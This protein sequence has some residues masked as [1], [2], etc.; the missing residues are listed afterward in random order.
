MEEALPH[1][2]AEMPEMTH[3]APPVATLAACEVWQYV[4]GKST[5]KPVSM[6]PTGGEFPVTRP[7]TRPAWS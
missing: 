2:R 4:A 3:I 5:Y 7:C 1:L 6:V